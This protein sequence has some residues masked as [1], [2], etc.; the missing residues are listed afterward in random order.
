MTHTRNMGPLCFLI[1]H[2]MTRR[3]L[4]IVRLGIGLSLLLPSIAPRVAAEAWA[5]EGTSA[6][7]RLE[8]RFAWQTLAPRQTFAAGPTDRRPVTAPTVSIPPGGDVSRRGI[9]VSGILGFA[10]LLGPGRFGLRAQTI[11]TGEA[12]SLWQ[13]IASGSREAREQAKKDLIKGLWS[14]D[15]MRRE[16][17]MAVV[18]RASVPDAGQTFFQAWVTELAATSEGRQSLAYVLEFG[19]DVA[20]RLVAIKALSAYPIADIWGKEAP[21]RLGR[22][23]ADPED[24]IAEAAIAWGA[25]DPLRQARPSRYALLGVLWTAIQLQANDGLQPADKL[26]PPERLYLAVAEPEDM[27]LVLNAAR[28]RPVLRMLRLAP[29]SGPRWTDRQVERLS[30]ELSMLLSDPYLRPEVVKLL[31]TVDLSAYPHTPVDAVLQS[32]IED[33]TVAEHTGQTERIQEL[34]TVLDHWLMRNETMKGLL[35]VLWEE[36]GLSSPDALATVIRLLS[37]RSARVVFTD[38]PLMP[39]RF[40]PQLPSWIEKR[41]RRAQDRLNA[42]A[43]LAKLPLPLEKTGL[44]EQIA[45]A[46]TEAESDLA[47]EEK[48]MRLMNAWMDP[49]RR[50]DIEKEMDAQT[51]ESLKRQLAYGRQYPEAF[52]IE[53]LASAQDDA[54]QARLIA[55]LG[56][57]P[58]LSRDRLNRPA[59]LAR[60][61][62]HLG[63]PKVG[64]IAYRFLRSRFW[65]DVEEGR[66]APY[67]W[68]LLLALDESTLKPAVDRNKVQVQVQQRLRELEK[69]RPSGTPASPRIELF[70]SISDDA[71]AVLMP[72]LINDG[73]LHPS[74]VA[75]VAAGAGISADEFKGWLDS[76]N[77]PGR[78]AAIRREYESAKRFTLFGRDSLIFVFASLRD[79][80]SVKGALTVFA[81]EQRSPPWSL[82][83]DAVRALFRWADQPGFR[84]WVEKAIEQAKDARLTR[85][86]RR[87]VVIETPPGQLKAAERAWLPELIEG[88]DAA[89]LDA[90]S[91][92][93]GREID[94]PATTPP[95]ARQAV[96]AVWAA[97]PNLAVEMN[98]VPFETAFRLRELL[99]WVA[100]R[101]L[102]LRAAGN[103]AEWDRLARLS[104]QILQ[105]KW[106]VSV[107][108][109]LVDLILDASRRQEL[110]AL[111]ARSNAGTSRSPVQT[112]A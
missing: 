112:A 11:D 2:P 78:A 5:S 76:V 25:N 101:Q 34:T 105:G 87:H 51:S 92:H 22:L 83:P 31:A 85:A 48:A 111:V 6:I 84:P 39:G 21:A 89:L 23:L 12:R 32:V 46:R 42:L 80:Q 58:L 53:Q 29:P 106:T 75:Y 10:A 100:G 63:D 27:F 15:E 91:A 43:L 70:Y 49:S 36:R 30:A 41:Q 73:F 24:A 61:F 26:T 35:N 13:T 9:V 3:P 90:V 54:D 50:A 98:P 1:D 47:D 110:T 4:L 77:D 8:S 19:V 96:L 108:Q 102:S 104:A 37:D 7:R 59:V 79:P 82:W 16:L 52:V 38:L 18:E 95:A 55:Q 33:L 62:R 109:S 81:K 68:P 99:R 40:E 74:E 20:A 56:E 67:A 107:L 64:A 71:K 57:F 66:W 28:A 17:V 72:E 97:A 65:L 60:L 93:A 94:L 14:G 44:G 103:T 69:Q 45:R 88:A 86:W